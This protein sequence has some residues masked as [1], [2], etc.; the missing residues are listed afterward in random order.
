[1]VI[2]GLVKKNAV[3]QLALPTSANSKRDLATTAA[4]AKV[5]FKAINDHQEVFYNIERQT[6]NLIG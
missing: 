3:N 2:M 6:C 4:P 1:M 5:G